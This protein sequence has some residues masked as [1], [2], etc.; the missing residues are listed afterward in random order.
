MGEEAEGQ[1][2]VIWLLAGLIAM[3]TAVSVVLAYATGMI[4]VLGHASANESLHGIVSGRWGL[5]ERVGLS[6]F[7]A[8]QGWQVYVDYEVEADAGSL[9]L[10]LHEPWV[11]ID[12]KVSEFKHVGGKSRGRVVFDVPRSSV[13]SFD[14]QGS[15]LGGPVDQRGYDLSYSITWGIQRR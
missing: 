4:T 6:T 2:L 14:Y 10:W 13:Y 9:R 1:R 3:L 7:Y 15:V 8:P 11:P 12:R 5:I